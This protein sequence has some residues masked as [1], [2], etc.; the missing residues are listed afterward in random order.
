MFFSDSHLHLQSF[1]TITEQDLFLEEARRNNI[2]RFICNGTKQSDW[3]NLAEIAARHRDVIP[4]FGL[5]PWYAHSASLD[6]EDELRNLLIKYPFGIGEIGLD[7]SRKMLSIPDSILIQEDIFRRQLAIAVEMSLPTSIH[8]VKSWDL[9][10]NIF[11]STEVPQSLMFHAFSGSAQVLS[12]L[13]NYGAYFS[14]AYNL[15]SEE[16]FLTV[17]KEIPSD[18]ILIE[19]DASNITDFHKSAGVTYI[20]NK[21]AE[22]RNE[23][24]ETLAASIKENIKNFLS[25][26]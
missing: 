13:L 16:R 3:Q 26:R 24:K 10:L 9:L 18:R 25:Y 15:L 19:T 1:G 7:R 2:T 22:V 17:I 12:K 4:F 14:F 5:H 11:S 21:I 23:D 20:F 6:W 8:I